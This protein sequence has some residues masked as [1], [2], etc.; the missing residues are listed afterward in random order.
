[1]QSYESNS[2]RRKIPKGSDSSKKK[3]MIN[4]L[5]QGGIKEALIFKGNDNHA[6]KCTSTEEIPLPPGGGSKEATL[7]PHPKA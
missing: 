2:I 3:S 4:L 5:D 6:Q 1:M 7:F